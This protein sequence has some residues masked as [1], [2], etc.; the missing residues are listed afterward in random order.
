MNEGATGGGAGHLV[1]AKI[2]SEADDSTHICVI[3]MP[4]TLKT[5]L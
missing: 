1:R 5:I 4:K 2:T 3:E